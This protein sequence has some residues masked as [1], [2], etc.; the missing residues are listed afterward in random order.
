MFCSVVGLCPDNLGK[1]SGTGRE[2]FLNIKATLF[3]N[4]GISLG[5]YSYLPIEV[6]RG[7]EVILWTKR[8]KTG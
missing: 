7:S 5:S 6:S 2:W 3:I 4:S 8:V 1:A